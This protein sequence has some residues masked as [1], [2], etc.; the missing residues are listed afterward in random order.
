[1]DEKLSIAMNYKNIKGQN[2]IVVMFNVGMKLLKILDISTLRSSVLEFKHPLN[3]LRIFGDYLYAIQENKIRRI[4]L[5]EQRHISTI[6]Y[7]NIADFCENREVNQIVTTEDGFLIDFL[8]PFD[9][10]KQRY[11][12]RQAI[13]EYLIVIVNDCVL[14]YKQKQGLI[15]S[16]IMDEFEKIYLPVLKKKDLSDISENR[17]LISS[18]IYFSIHNM[19]I[20]VMVDEKIVGKD[21]NFYLSD[22]YDLVRQDRGH[23]NIVISKFVCISDHLL[24]FDDRL[25][26]VF[27]VE[28]N[29]EKIL[30]ETECSDFFYDTEDNNLF[31]VDGVCLKVFHE[32]CPFIQPFKLIEENIVY[33]EKEDEFDSSNDFS[34]DLEQ[35]ISEVCV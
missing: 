7:S 17:E 2:K 16:I 4:R 9:V 34:L 13:G 20:Y 24:L 29:C 22:F 30:F 8:Y 25:G 35:E 1:M 5:S 23:E 28:K 15:K 19:K 3:D 11:L 32:N 27:F 33:K 6:I 12:Y 18:K 26:R 21:L 31:T 10:V 14:I